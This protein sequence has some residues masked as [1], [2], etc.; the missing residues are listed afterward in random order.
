MKTIT[1]ITIGAVAGL[2]TASPVLNT[3]ET[4]FSVDPAGWPSATMTIDVS[5]YQFNDALGS[6]LNEVLSVF[7]GNSATITGIYWN[8]NL[9][10]IGASWGSEATML[11]DS[12]LALAFSQDA[13]PVTNQNYSGGFDLTDFGSNNILVS[14]DG[15]VDIEFY[16]T[17]VDNAGTGDSYFEA[18]STLTFSGYAHPTPGTLGALGLGGFMLGRRRR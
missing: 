10:S 3:S 13:A 5:G 1:L 2:A 18:G 17:F 15:I 8:L 12:Q 6:P 16:D 11:I 14:A 4:S 9:S 7:V